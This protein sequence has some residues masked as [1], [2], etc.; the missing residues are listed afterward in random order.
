MVTGK[1][2]R[3]VFTGSSG[4]ANESSC[5]VRHGE[6]L[7]APTTLSGSNELYIRQQISNEMAR[8]Y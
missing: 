7:S 3:F 1:K 8:R 5:F 4:E 2:F 6:F